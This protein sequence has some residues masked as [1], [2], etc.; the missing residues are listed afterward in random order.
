VAEGVG[1]GTPSTQQSSRTEWTGFEADH[2]GALRCT[3]VVHAGPLGRSCFGSEIAWLVFD[4]ERVLAT[5]ILDTDGEFLAVVFARDFKEGYRSTGTTESFSNPVEALVRLQPT[6][7]ALLRRLDEEPSQGD[8]VGK[9][10]DFFAPVYP[11]SKLSPDFLALM[12]SEGYSPARGIIEPMMRCYEDA[13]GNFVEQFQTTGYDARI[14]ELYLF[15][16]LSE[17]GFTIDRTLSAPDFI[18]TGLHGEFCVEA[19]TIQPS[20]DHGQ[21]VPSPSPTT[22]DEVLAFAREYLPIRYAGL[23]TTKLNKRYWEQPHV[24]GKPLLFAIQ[25]FHE[26]TSMT[27]SRTGLPT[28]LYGYVHDPKRE[29][30]GSL[31]VVPTKVTTHR[32]GKKVIPSGFFEFPDAENL[33][34]VLFN[35]AGTIVKFNRMGVIAGFG[36]ED[37]ILVRNGTVMNSDPNASDPNKF[38]HVVNKE[39]METWIEGMDVYHNPRALHPLDPAMLPGAAHHR[40]L[41]DGEVESIVPEWHPLGSLTSI[42]VMRGADKSAATG[43]GSQ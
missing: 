24:A 33:G 6:A 38:L 27:W 1:I 21:P 20:M 16:A 26:P 34:A 22:P 31:T 10:V 35:N 2:K 3:R 40:L 42:L 37:V 17:A 43:G 11:P 19:T 41:Q 12:T 30:D 14:W 25:D 32:G 5:L 13:D 8:E 7:D 29:A 18:A 39:Y 23:L 15:V 9:P 36:S 4:D 28:C